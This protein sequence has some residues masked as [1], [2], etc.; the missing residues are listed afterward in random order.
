MAQQKRRQNVDIIKPYLSPD[1]ALTCGS[2]NTYFAS[3]DRQSQPR[4]WITYELPE[5][6]APVDVDFFWYFRLCGEVCRESFSSK[7]CSVKKLPLAKKKLGLFAQHFTLNKS[8]FLRPDI[9]TS[10]V[11]TSAPLFGCRTFGGTGTSVSDDLKDISALVCMGDVLDTSPLA[12]L[13]SNAHDAIAN[14][15]SAVPASAASFSSGA[16]VGTGLLVTSEY[17]E[18][19]APRECCPADYVVKTTK[20]DGEEGQHRISFIWPAP[21]E[22]YGSFPLLF[23]ILVY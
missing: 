20:D 19:A 1:P 13:A 2:C 15:A 7:H 6:C 23:C 5:G 18:P 21:E 8:T 17:A 11:G 14:I 22:R 12:S 9:P 4:D 16:V 10:A 3:G